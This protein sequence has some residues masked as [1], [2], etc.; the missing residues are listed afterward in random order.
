LVL[1]II[2]SFI[3]RKVGTLCGAGTP[4]KQ[5]VFINFKETPELEKPYIDYLV[6]NYNYVLEKPFF[7]RK[8]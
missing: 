2:S 4:S 7:L 5:G 3:Y 6:K 8:I 1:L